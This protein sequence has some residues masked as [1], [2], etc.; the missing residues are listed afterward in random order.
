[1]AR[2]VTGGADPKRSIDLLWGEAEPGR[3]GPKPRY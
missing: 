3:R 1:M 2:D